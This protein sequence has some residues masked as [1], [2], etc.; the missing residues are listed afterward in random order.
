VATS[1]LPQKL[2]QSFMGLGLTK[3]AIIVIINVILLFLGGFAD[4]LAIILL[5]LP[6]FIPL[7]Y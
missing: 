5:T 3:W 2:D 4:T 6:F 1:G 7:V